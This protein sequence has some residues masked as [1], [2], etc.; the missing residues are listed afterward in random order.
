MRLTYNHDAPSCS[1]CFDAGV[2]ADPRSAD[3]DGVPDLLPCPRKGCGAREEN[4]MYRSYDDWKCSPPVDERELE[5]EWSS[6]AA[7]LDEIERHLAAARHLG[8]LPWPLE[9]E[10]SW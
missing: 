4:E 10:L 7:E 2:I 1:E 9:E 8:E 3:E 6:V 5:A